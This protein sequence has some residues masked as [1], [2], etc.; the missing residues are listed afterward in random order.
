M[1]IGTLL[2]GFPGTES[3]GAARLGKHRMASQ[4]YNNTAIASAT[5]P[6]RET[7]SYCENYECITGTIFKKA[8]WGASF[9]CRTPCG[10]GLRAYHLPAP[11]D[12]LPL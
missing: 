4:P 6:H 7:A 11:P 2:F 9:H 12:A 1:V 8:P 3:T 10:P 5:V